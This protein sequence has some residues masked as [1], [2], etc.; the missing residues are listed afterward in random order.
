VVPRWD[1]DAE[2]ALAHLDDAVG[3]TGGRPPRLLRAAARAGRARL[4]AAAGDEAAAVAALDPDDGRRAPVEAVVSA[5][6]QLA[7]GD[8]AAAVRTLAPLLP[9]GPGEPP[10]LPLAIEACLVDA[11]ASQELA[12]HVA[13]VRSMRLALDLAAPEGYRRVFVEG[14]PPVRMLLADHLHWDSAHHLLVGSLLERLRTATPPEGRAGG[15]RAA[16][17]APLV[18]PLSE[19]EQ[20]VLRYLSSRLSAGEIADELYVS[21]NTVKTHIKS[22]YRKLDTNR[23]WDAVKRARQLQLL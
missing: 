23:R 2:T 18:V 10:E 19:R 4:L 3:A 6:L 13:A 21:L 20:V 8:P 1:G 12:D 9:G 17:P 22:I 7:G 11:V 5:R 16:D 15:G 14:G